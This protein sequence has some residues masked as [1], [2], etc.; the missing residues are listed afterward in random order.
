MKSIFDEH[1]SEVEAINLRRMASHVEG[2]LQK[3]HETFIG[4]ETFLTAEIS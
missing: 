2:L 3:A 4:Q 1:T